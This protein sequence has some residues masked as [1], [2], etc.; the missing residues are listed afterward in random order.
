MKYKEPLPRRKKRQIIEVVLSLLFLLTTVLFL[1][2]YF[3]SKT[4]E[5]VNLG[6]T[7]FQNIIYNDHY[8]DAYYFC[9]NASIASAA[10]LIVDSAFS[11]IKMLIQQNKTAS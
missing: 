6:G 10:V 1:I 9:L 8:A 4:Y 5:L 11:R 3:R 2:L 7:Q